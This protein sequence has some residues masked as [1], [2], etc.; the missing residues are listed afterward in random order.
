MNNLLTGFRSV[1]TAIEHVRAKGRAE[2]ADKHGEPYK[3]FYINRY[4]RTLTGKPL[5]AIAKKKS[6]S[7]I[8]ALDVDGNIMNQYPNNAR[9]NDEL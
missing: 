4:G 3:K 6:D 2:F 1:S 8:V 9:W 5:Y 7:T